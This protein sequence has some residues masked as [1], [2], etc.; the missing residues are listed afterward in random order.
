MRRSLSF[1]ASLAAPLAAVLLA[2]SFVSAQTKTADELVK[3]E[4]LSSSATVAPGQTVTVAIRLKIE[5]KWHVY[6]LNPGDSGQATAPRLELPP[7]WKQTPWRFPN[8]ITFS[9]PGDFIGYGYKDELVLLT[10]ITPPPETKPGGVTLKALVVYLVCDDVCLPGSA[11]LKLDLTVGPDATP[12]PESFKTWDAL[13]PAPDP[14]VP[15]KVE[16]TLGDGRDWRP[17]VATVAVGGE[18]SKVEV[19]PLPPESLELREIKAEPV[20]GGGVII[21]MEGKL[22]SGQT[23]APPTLRVLIVVTRSNGTRAGQ[24]VDVPT[25]LVPPPTQGK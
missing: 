9:Q 18:V 16:G 3:A 11:H 4:L 15:A 20:D 21:K 8:P 10:D 5:P 23:V 17:L 22:Y 13:M 1:A 2:A 24:W 25:G 7:G 19:Y 6:W 12:A 14:V